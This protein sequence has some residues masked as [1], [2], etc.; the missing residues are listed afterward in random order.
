ATAYGSRLMCAVPMMREG[1]AIG[2][3]GIR[4][5]EPELLTDNEI[6]IIQSFANQAPIAIGNVRQFNETQRLLRE[7][8]QRRSELAVINS[9]Q[10]GMA[11][12][13]E[14][15]A[16]VDLVG[17]KLR[18]L[19][20]TGDMAIRWRDEKTDLVHQLYVYEH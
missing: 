20:R 5:V 10:Q 1:E 2:V 12:E 19:F 3:I 7:T 16:N 14:F 11:A 6:A 8:E 18:E 17:D 4:R 15:Q 13:R 9:I